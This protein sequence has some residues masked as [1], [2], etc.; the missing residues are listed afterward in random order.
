MDFSLNEEQQ[1]VRDTAKEFADKT[2]KPRA[3]DI[4][5]NHEYRHESR[6]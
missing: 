5:K 2:I 3:E 4:D 1:I 6:L